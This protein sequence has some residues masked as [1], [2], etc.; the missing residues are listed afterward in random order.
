M[1]A[2]TAPARA[3]LIGEHTDY[4]G[5]YVLPM[6]LD[7]A[8][9]V[10]V[11]RTDRPG[12]VFLESRTLARNATIEGAWSRRGDWTDYPVGCLAVLRKR[13]ISLPGLALRIESTVPMGAGVS[14][15]AA[16]EVA[17]LKAVRGL[18]GLELD[19][20][21]IALLAQR[22]ESEFVGVPCGI[23]DQ[24]IASLGRPGEAMLIDTRDLSRRSVSLPRDHVFAVLHSGITHK[25]SESGYGE[26]RRE[27]GDAAQ[28]LGVGTLR[29]VAAEDHRI[30]RLPEP[31]PRRV[32]HVLSENARV[33][34][35]VE[36]LA[37]GRIER[38]GRLM[39]ASH[40]SQ[41]DDF[42]VSIPEIDALVAAAMRHG[43]AGAR[44]TGGGFGGSIIAL[45]RRDQVEGWTRAMQ[46]E[47]P[48][49]SLIAP[50]PTS[51]LAP[52]SA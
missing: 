44:L 49:T 48:Q 22:A 33:L 42:E 3:N 5:G 45:L 10:T 50:R 14:S 34:A 1:I 4:N 13:G 31:L 8:T 15:S 38:V 28:R 9:T 12:T 52:D 27:C 30:A 29:E 36:A 25:L 6:P 16:L 26:R 39:L 51:P 23:M 11:E 2:A 20:V 47:F 41:R 40:E 43:A 24:M 18:L 46:A 7:C 37:D 21:E 32:R 19:D 17:T 35:M